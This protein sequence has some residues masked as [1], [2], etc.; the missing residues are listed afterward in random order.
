MST[1]RLLLAA[2]LLKPVLDRRVNQTRW[3]VL[4]WPTSAMAQ[5]AG[6]SIEAFE[7]FYFGVCTLD[8]R[9]M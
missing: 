3:V 9:R 6:M 7:D 1:D 4:R 5:M 8:Y 2:K